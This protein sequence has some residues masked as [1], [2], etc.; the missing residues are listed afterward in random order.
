MRHISGDA[1]PTDLLSRQ[2][3]LNALVTEGSVEDRNAR[4]VQQVQVLSDVSDSGIQAPLHQL[5]SQFAQGIQGP[6]GDFVQSDEPPFI[7]AIAI[8]KL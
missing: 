2:L 7:A 4:H 6:Q 5:L 1:N 8:S 3:I